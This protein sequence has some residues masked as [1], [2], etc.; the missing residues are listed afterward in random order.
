L[1]VSGGTSQHENKEYIFPTSVPTPVTPQLSPVQEIWDTLTLLDAKM[2]T[3]YRDLIIFANGLPLNPGNEN[4]QQMLDSQSNWIGD[5]IRRL[6][7]T[8]MLGDANLTMLVTKM[9]DRAN[10]IQD[11]ITTLRPHLGVSA[12][13]AT[14]M[15]IDTSTLHIADS[16]NGQYLMKT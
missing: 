13:V 1:T 2:D 14:D 10:K 7:V 16:S 5:L 12:R 8:P 9:I 4:A 6:E 11:F 15:V 3:R